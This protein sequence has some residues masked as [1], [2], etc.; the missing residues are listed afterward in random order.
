[1]RANSNLCV[2]L[3]VDQGIWP[4]EKAASADADFSL[5]LA[6]ALGALHQTA[7]STL[8][9]EVNDRPRIV[10]NHRGDN[11]LCVR[12]EDDIHITAAY[13]PRANGK[14]FRF[15]FRIDQG[16]NTVS[17]VIDRDIED[18]W[19]SGKLARIGRASLEDE[20]SR[21][22]NER[23]RFLYYTIIKKVGG[24]DASRINISS[25]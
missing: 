22:I 1:M 12:D 19:R 6:R 5:Q 20:I 4:I 21:D 3:G 2:S 15:S 8:P 18:E 23:A 17:G 24:N 13:L 11:P 9:R 10:L 25:H 16:H 14:P 7:G